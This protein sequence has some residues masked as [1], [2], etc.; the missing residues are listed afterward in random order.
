[1]VQSCDSLEKKSFVGTWIAA[2]KATIEFRSNNVVQ[3]KNID[4]NKIFYNP[5]STKNEVSFEGKWNFNSEKN[6]VNINSNM[7]HFTLEVIGQGFLGNEPPY[8]LV[9]W[10]GDPDEINKYEFIKKDGIFKK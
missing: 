8:N 9:L 1:M 5:K 6:I 4:K 10:V 3:L 2:D 7:Y